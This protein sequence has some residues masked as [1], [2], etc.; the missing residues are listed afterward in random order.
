VIAIGRP[1]SEDSPGAPAYAPNTQRSK[2]RS[3]RPHPATWCPGIVDH[4]QRWGERAGGKPARTF[5][6]RIRYAG[7][8]DHPP[9]AE[10]PAVRGLRERIAQLKEASPPGLAARMMLRDAPR[11]ADGVLDT[12]V[13]RQFRHDQLFSPWEGNGAP[14]FVTRWALKHRS[15]P[16]AWFVTFKT[17]AMSRAR[18][19]DPPRARGGRR[20]GG[21]VGAHHGGVS[22]ASGR[23]GQGVAYSDEFGVT[24]PFMDLAACLLAILEVAEVQTKMFGTTRALAVGPAAL[25]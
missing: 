17:S 9:P 23:E 7:C 11:A 1:R 10:R 13:R 15:R 18:D 20:G 19:T 16:T 5:P 14:A 21:A 6:R 12:A 4:R 22:A 24:K 3:R 25:F 8:G 2:S